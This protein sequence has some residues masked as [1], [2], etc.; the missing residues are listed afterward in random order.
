M[1]ERWCVGENGENAGDGGSSEGA[2]KAEAGSVTRLEDDAER[3]ERDG[4]FVGVG[5]D[6]AGEGVDSRGEKMVQDVIVGGRLDDGCI[7]GGDVFYAEECSHEVS[8][9]ERIR[10]E[11]Q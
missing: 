5:L 10:K 11:V 6:K 2:G 1:R 4:G 8:R 3:S 9:N 7:K